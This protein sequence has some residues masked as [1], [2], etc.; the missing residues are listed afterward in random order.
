PPHAVVSLAL[1]AVDQSGAGALEG[2]R[3]VAR[4]T[5]VRFCESRRSPQAARPPTWPPAMTDVRLVRPSRVDN[6][7]HWAV[8]G[9]VFGQR[10]TF[11]T[12]PRHAPLRPPWRA[13]RRRVLVLPAGC[14]RCPAVRQ[15][16]VTGDA[17]PHLG[18]V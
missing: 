14:V 10:L 18:P 11:A 13:P 3:T 8:I 12:P 7:G 1:E 17:G 16:P 6:S 15:D 9:G 2:L 4:S 5:P